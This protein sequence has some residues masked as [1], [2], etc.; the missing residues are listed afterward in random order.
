MKGYGSVVIL[1]LFI[2]IHNNLWNRQQYTKA[3]F[4]YF[5]KVNEGTEAVEGF[6]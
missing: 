3:S 4:P 2:H 1:L 5:H 6:Y